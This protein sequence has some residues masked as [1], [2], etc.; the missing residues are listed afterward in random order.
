MS[1]YSVSNPGNPVGAYRNLTATFLRYRDASRA[2]SRPFN[3]QGVC[4]AWRVCARGRRLQRRAWAQVGEPVQA[5]AQGSPLLPCVLPS[6]RARTC[7][8]IS[9]S[10][11]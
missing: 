10:P 6:P 9:V 2:H 4:P 5:F 8:P 7:D 1:S 3:G 11:A